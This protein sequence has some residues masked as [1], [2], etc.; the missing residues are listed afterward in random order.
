[1]S[2]TWCFY[3][4][5]ISAN[6]I[7]NDCNIRI[8]NAPYCAMIITVNEIIANCSNDIME[9]TKSHATITT[10]CVMTEISL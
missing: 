10:N 8:I 3:G 5:S 2:I 1:M 4:S 7:T 6:C 9:Y